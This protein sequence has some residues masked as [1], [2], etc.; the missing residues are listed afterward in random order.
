MPE[1]FGIMSLI[2]SLMMGINL[3]SDI[4]IQQNIVRSK[5]YNNPDF[6]NTVWTLQIIRSFCVF[7]VIAIAA[8]PVSYFYGEPILTP[9]I[10]VSG[11]SVVIFGFV[12]TKIHI[13]S[14]QLTLGWK[15]Y[16]NVTSYVVGL[17]CMIGLALVHP[18]VWALPIGNLVGT[19]VKV[20]LSHFALPGHPNRLAW[21]REYLDEVFSFGR[22]ILVSSAT[23]FFS[24]QSDKFILARL[25]SF[26]VL[27]V[28][29]VAISLAQIPQGI[30]KSLNSSIFFP[31]VSQNA[32]LPRHELRR[33]ILAKR[34]IVLLA[35]AGF[36]AVSASVGDIL[37]ALAYDDRYSDA[38]WMFS[39]LCLGVWFTV[40]FYTSVPCLLGIGQSVYL[41]QGN[42]VRMLMM[43]IGIF[44]GFYL[45]DT[46]GAILAIAI[47]DFPGYL[48]L[49]NG[50]IRER[51]HLYR[52]DLLMTAAF[53]VF[54]TALLGIRYSIGFGTPFD[55]LFT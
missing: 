5:H 51:L 2:S 1:Y 44:V 52:Q 30:I 32:E 55:L 6:L 3:F 26:S 49:Q 48:A 9:L 28:Y 11:F 34:Q 40:L 43:T 19:I 25:L 36:I 35:F 23:M 20:A 45:G 17:L 15:T 29:T 38:T 22:W 53:V 10:I 54:V 47:S 50:L 21:H 16:I 41:A 46:L 27:G 33:K 8:F 12:S 14:R 39:I 4:G 24:E 7:A 37:I 42:F 31:L 13:M 18:S